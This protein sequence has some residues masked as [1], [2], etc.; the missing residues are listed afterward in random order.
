MSKLSEE[1]LLGALGYSDSPNYRSIADQYHPLTAHLF[2]AASRAG[3]KGA[4]LFHTSTNDEI[5]PPRPAVYVADANT[6][7]EAREIH[8]SLWNLGN[9]PFLIVILPSEI[10]IYTG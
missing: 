2:R 6:R 4:Y 3:A 5:L 8:R 7:E 10:R 9:A 1:R